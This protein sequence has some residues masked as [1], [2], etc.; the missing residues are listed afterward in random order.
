MYNDKVI[1][2]RE[3]RE[4]RQ[5]K[6]A[7]HG[8]KVPCPAVVTNVPRYQ[9]GGRTCIQV[10]PNPSKPLPKKKYRQRAGKQ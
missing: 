4:G 3:K 1:E 5:E 7:G 6:R 2:E 8:W 9:K 10:V